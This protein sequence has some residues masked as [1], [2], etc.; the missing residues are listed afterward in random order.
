MPNPLP[1]RLPNLRADFARLL[2]AMNVPSRD[3]GRAFTRPQR[4][5]AIR[6]LL[7]RRP[8]GAPAWRRVH[9][10]PLAL[11]YAHPHLGREDRVLM[12]SCHIDSLYDDHFASVL[13][14]GHT[15]GQLVG[16]FDNSICNAVAVDLM[17]RGKLPRNALV[18][19]TGD[20]EE[21]SRGAVEALEF[22]QT[23]D[24]EL[25]ERLEAVVVMDVTG[26]SFGR[27]AFTVE[28]VFVE[29][30]PMPRQ[31]LVFKDAGA[32]LRRIK[33]ALP[34][35]TVKYVPASKADP[36]ET[37]VYDEHDLNCFLLALP[38]APGPGGAHDDWMHDAQGIRVRPEDVEGYAAA[39]GEVVAGLAR[40]VR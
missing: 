2:R 14:G 27:R 15:D 29:R 19:F 39:L 26:V 31:R 24:Q 20:E 5:D 10:G 4:R 37:W 13:A 1:D 40:E 38:T 18:A 7:G 8:A 23:S 6:R 9:D 33:A 35:K 30:H 36:D 3:D 22:L 32:F 25:W 11:V 16:T 17:L 12:V 21:D 28:N 34:G